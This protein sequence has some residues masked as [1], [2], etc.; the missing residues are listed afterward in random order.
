[1]PSEIGGINTIVPLYVASH[2][3]VAV[4][5]ADGSGRAAPE[6]ATMLFAHPSLTQKLLTLKAFFR[7]ISCLKA[8]ISAAQD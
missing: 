2:K 3:N 7:P 8:Q 6:L 1:M 4:V 5:D